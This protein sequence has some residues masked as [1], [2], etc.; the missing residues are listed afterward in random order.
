MGV[1]EKNFVNNVSFVEN[2]ITNKMVKNSW[3]GDAYKRI[4]NKEENKEKTNLY[5]DSA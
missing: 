4:K 1:F 5:V 3:G 2:K